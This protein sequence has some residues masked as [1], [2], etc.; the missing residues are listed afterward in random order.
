MCKA[1]GRRRPGTAREGEREG[2]DGGRKENHPDKAELDP[3]VRLGEV[4][5]RHEPHEDVQEQDT[6]WA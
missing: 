3:V 4:V 1:D 5:D 2:Y 6:P